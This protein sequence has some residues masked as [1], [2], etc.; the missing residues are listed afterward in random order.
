VGITNPFSVARLSSSG[1]IIPARC[2]CS[3]CRTFSLVV[4]RGGAYGPSVPVLRVH[5]DSYIGL[6]VCESVCTGSH[7][8][9][10]ACGSTLG[11]ILL[12]GGWV[13]LHFLSQHTPGFLLCWHDWNSLFLVYG[14]AGFPSW[15][16]YFC[17][18]HY[19]VSQLLKYQAFQIFGKIVCDH[20]ACGTIFNTDLFRLDSV[21]D[22]KIPYCNMSCSFPT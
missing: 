9:L 1:Y 4:R 11:K 15:Q 3:I 21:C 17:I 16:S 13:N 7:A 6:H 5:A 10:F 19:H 20:D 22:E 18:S 2:W 12:G 14:D 8:G